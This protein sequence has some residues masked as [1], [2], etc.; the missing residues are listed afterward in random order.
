[1][2]RAIEIG[3]RVWDSEGRAWVVRA[4]TVSRRTPVAYVVEVEH[5]CRPCKRL[6]AREVYPSLAEVIQRAKRG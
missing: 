5:G 1:V 3:A 4:V 2:K 6:R